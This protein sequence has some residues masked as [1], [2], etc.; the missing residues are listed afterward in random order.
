MPMG[1]DIN[2]PV[3]AL[4]DDWGAAFGASSSPGPGQHARK[5]ARSVYSGSIAA[6]LREA[7]VDGE[8]PAGTPLVETKLAER[9]S[10][11]RGPI[12]SAMHALEGEGLIAT[13]PNGRSAVVGFGERDLRDLF[14][15]RWSIE[16]TAAR[17]AIE[18]QR[19]LAPVIETFGAME[20]EGTSTPRLV[21]LDI[22]FHRALLEVSGSRFLLQAW[23]A[24]APV[25]HTVIT[26]GNR[27]L[28]ARDPRSNFAR[29]VRS[30]QEIVDALAAGD[31]DR[32]TS[33]LADQFQF[34]SSMFDGDGEIERA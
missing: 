22:R 19:D 5:L 24:I 27:T 32:A 3:A 23:L 9:M 4:V 15:A 16:S 31:A 12:R 7:I 18:Q 21:E 33:R 10:V 11:S 2:K 28:A 25:I 1:E 6:M 29:I 20:A 34:T 14:G 8:L 17:W 13:Q 30:H 26:I